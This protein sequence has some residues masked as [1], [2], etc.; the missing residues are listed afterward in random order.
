MPTEFLTC[1][2]LQSPASTPMARSSPAHSRGT[3]MGHLQRQMSARELLSSSME[4]GVDALA[5]WNALTGSAEEEL[6]DDHIHVHIHS[7]SF[8][9]PPQL[10]AEPEQQW[11]LPL[12]GGSAQTTTT[13]LQERE[14]SIH[15]NKEVRTV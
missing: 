3:S 13:Q 1:S 7:A 15:L 6:T 2:P 10:E 8:E 12:M 11:P 14:T 5:L 9:V 4:T